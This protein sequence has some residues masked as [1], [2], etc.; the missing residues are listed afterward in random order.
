MNRRNDGKP[1][2]SAIFF[3][4]LMAGF[5]TVTVCAFILSVYG[6]SWF[7]EKDRSR[8]MLV[9]NLLANEID[10]YCYENQVDICS[11]S[12]TDLLSQI[13]PEISDQYLVLVADSSGHTLADSPPLTGYDDS[14]AP[15]FDIIL[16]GSLSVSPGF[17]SGISRQLT[18][19]AYSMIISSEQY[20]IL[21]E[22]ESVIQRV[23]YLL[24]AALIFIFVVY[25][26]FT[27]LGASLRQRKITRFVQHLA[28]QT[29]RL[30]QGL[31][32]ES[33]GRQPYRELTRLASSF[34]QLNI[35]L[36]ER[37]NQLEQLAFTD[38][39]TGLSNRNRLLQVL[40]KKIEDYTDQPFAVLFLDLDNFKRINDSYGHPF[41]DLLLVAISQ[42]LLKIRPPSEIAARIGGDE[43]VLVLSGYSSDNHLQQRIDSLLHILHQPLICESKRVKLSFSIG[44]A[45][46]PKDGPSAFDLLKCADM[47]LYAAKE[48][49]KSTWRYFDHQMMIDLKRH[50]YLEQALDTVL[51]HD[52]LQV[53]Y[54]IQIFTQTR[55]IRGFEALIR[56]NSRELGY[57]SANELISAAEG[58]GQIIQIGAWVLRQA[59]EMIIRI[60]SQF[61][62]KLIICV[63]VSPIELQHP[64]YINNLK[65]ILEQTGL[66]P[67][68]L[69]LEVTEQVMIDSG[70]AMID[71]LDKIREL[72][73]SLALDDFGTG[74]SSLAYLQHLPVQTI[75]IDRSFVADLQQDNRN[76]QMLE[77]ILHMTKNLNMFS[78]AEGIENKDQA[79]L[80]GTLNCDCLQGF[81]ICR[82]LPEQQLVQVLL[83]QTGHQD[84]N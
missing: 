5:L 15:G 82:P 11:S 38:N 20:V 54:Q 77:S 73:V 75:K 45:V 81:H 71:I 2:L 51:E 1:L 42:R 31:T 72:G 36:Q 43:F 21:Y 8:G 29:Q 16:K 56:W 83:A 28:W 6:L 55:R 46:F 37:N 12:L 18:P 39:L 35:Q 64:E 26:L 49:G 10:H 52:E 61:K 48:A 69:E 4:N 34:D 60:N 25:L 27:L 78:I 66:E 24:L 44:A 70:Y 13:N 33:L 14:I 63:N 23:T 84:L 3:S 67:S 50:I 59:C 76:W 41:G 32:T 7:T 79:D 40:Y 58:N 53:S 17:T 62:Q 30:A 74:Y 68:L 65:R 9:A 57:V 22:T 80:L 19:I 47:A